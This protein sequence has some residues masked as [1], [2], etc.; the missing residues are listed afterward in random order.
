VRIFLIILF[1]LSLG[2]VIEAPVRASVFGASNDIIGGES[3]NTADA[4]ALFWYVDGYFEMEGGPPAAANKW[5]LD[6]PTDGKALL[7]DTELS[8]TPRLSYDV[9][10]GIGFIDDG[11]LTDTDFDAASVI[12]DLSYSTAAG[13]WS[14]LGTNAY[15]RL[16]GS[17][18][19]FFD[20]SVGYLYLRSSVDYRDPNIRIS[21]Y[22]PTNTSWQ[23]RWLEYDLSYY[24]VRFGARGKVDF[25]DSF[26]VKAAAG[27][28][29]GLKAKYDGMRYP[30]RPVPQQQTERIEATGV[31]V[32]AAF[33]AEYF[34][35]A[36]L[37]LTAGYKYMLFE[38]EGWD[39]GGTPWAGSWER[40]NMELKG[41]FAGLTYSY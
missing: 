30:E 5:I 18:S 32:D 2:F 28:I 31:G 17:N 1:S 34:V 6:H 38:T 4:S 27:I 23:E 22:A 41:P 40:L 10:L 9:A 19:T 37:A 3:K 29:P 16:L 7:F 36:N 13:F 11:R 39:K 33:S 15:I 24:G 8:L 25:S 14:I 26:S 35:S 12:S 20:L 21:A